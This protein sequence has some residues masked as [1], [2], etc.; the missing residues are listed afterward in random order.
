KN[1][2]KGI[3]IEKEDKRRK[4][5]RDREK[6][7]EKEGVGALRHFLASAPTIGSWSLLAE[8]TEIGIVAARVSQRLFYSVFSGPT[9]KFLA[10]V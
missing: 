8:L 2:E 3:V 10:I 9:L 6:E 4:G 1:G 7:S 5:K